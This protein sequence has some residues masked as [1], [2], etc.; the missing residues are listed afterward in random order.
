MTIRIGPGLTIAIVTERVSVFDVVIGVV[1]SVY[2]VYLVSGA[3]SNNT[4]HS[5]AAASVLV[6]LMTLPV[7]WRRRAP[8]AV[9]ATLAA[10]AVL[11]P[12]LI[13][14]M[15]RCGP[16]LPALLLCAYS[17]GRRPVRLTWA[18]TTV[19]LACL[20]LSAGVQTFTDPNLDSGVLVVMAPMI[21][22]LYWVGRL[23]RSRTELAVDLEQRNEQ[24]RR[25]RER[26]ADLAVRADR[27]R[28]AEGLDASL[29][30][31]ITAMGAAAESG[32]HAL[33]EE[34]S[35][36][37]AQTAFGV[38]QQRGRE[39]LTH[40]RGVVGSLLEPEPAGPQPSLSQ[41]DRLL[42]RAGPADVHLHVTGQP[43]ALPAGIELSLYRALEHLLDAYGA[44]PGSRVD[45]N[46]DFATE[47]L[48]LTVRGPAPEA[49]GLR[50]ALAA[51][52]ARGDIHHG[53][54][55]S[56]CLAGRWEATARL[57]V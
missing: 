23:I 57:P 37:A 38:I 56:D 42:E 16:A 40:M 36:E 54:L 49:I 32:R 6:L 21:I 13:G 24:L 27:A 15:V 10:G 51:A 52:Q 12:L 2:G 33:A 25:Q 43:R 17:V 45:V 34:Q 31:Q 14:P 18:A 20:V 8:V 35:T 47:A 44:V 9:A 5:G 55:S 11:N 46:V 1:L 41:L 30:A 19:A 26:R 48:A 7:V 29:R 22:G 28:I 4:R 39:T 53:S 50:A 3:V